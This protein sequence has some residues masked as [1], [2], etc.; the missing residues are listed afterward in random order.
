MGLSE[1]LISKVI[2]KELKTALP[3]VEQIEAELNES[4]HKLK[5]E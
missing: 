3:T 1:C 4:L 2:P 5:N